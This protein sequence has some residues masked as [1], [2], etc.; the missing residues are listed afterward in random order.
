MKR[1]L[2]GIALAATLGLL[3]L[4]TAA[5]A[6]YYDS[7]STTAT[8]KPIEPSGFD[9]Y[10]SCDPADAAKDYYDVWAI[11]LAAG[12][13]ITLSGSWDAGKRLSYKLINASGTSLVGPSQS[14]VGTFSITY[15]PSTAGTY[16][17]ALGDAVGDANRV[18]YTITYIKGLPPA[19]T[20][21]TLF[22]DP[23]YPAYGKGLV[24]RATLKSGTK[25]MSG[26]TVKFYRFGYR[27][28]KWV[29]DYFAS[30]T[31]DANGLASVEATIFDN[32]KTTYRAYYFGG[33]GYLPSS[34][35]RAVYPKVFLSAPYLPTTLVRG[36]GVA[37]Y[38]AIMPRHTSG[39]APVVIQRWRWNGSSW[40]L[41][42]TTLA[43]V[44][45]VSTYSKYSANIGFPYAGTWRLRAIAPTDADHIYTESAYR[46]VI[47][48]AP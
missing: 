5:F 31:T 32:K 27:S 37:V 10:V 45:D 29:W 35:D 48:R 18:I 12:Q 41:M 13:K 11:S 43:R 2:I 30:A 24:L 16:Y 1:R 21:I 44:S 4:P 8:A 22:S 23:P 39:T 36:Q 19:P 7:G 42:G 28:G 6:A 34:V 14:T 15:T 38:G 25:A 17:L 3:L 40:A 20:A 46:T 33:L 9:G 26:R 47:V